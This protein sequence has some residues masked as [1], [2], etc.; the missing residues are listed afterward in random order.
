MSLSRRSKHIS[1]CNMLVIATYQLLQHISHGN[2]LVIAIHTGTRPGEVAEQALERAPCDRRK[3]RAEHQHL[4]HERVACVPCAHA[5]RACVHV[6]V[7][8]RRRVCT[9]GRRRCRK[10]ISAGT[11][12]ALLSQEVELSWVELS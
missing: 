8:V 6:R 10:R 11:R 5:V 7:R 3:V 2:I 12:H 4:A 1:Y 9:S